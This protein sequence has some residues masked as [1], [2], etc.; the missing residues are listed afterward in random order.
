[1]EFVFQI[2]ADLLSPVDEKQVKAETKEIVEQAK[3]E[4]QTE[5]VTE[6]ETKN[7]NPNIFGVMDFH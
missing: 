5:K 2:L 4:V 6:T 3:E 1:M 7:E